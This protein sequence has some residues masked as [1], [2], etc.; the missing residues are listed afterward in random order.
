VSEYQYYEFR[1]LDRELTDGEIDALEAIS[2]RAQVTPTS[3]TNHYDWGDLKADPFKLLEKYFNAFVYVS[4]WGSRRFC[5]RVPKDSIDQEQVERLLK[6]DHAWTS[7]SRQYLILGLEISE[8]DPDFADDGTRWMQALL[9]LRSD[10]LRGD[11]RSLYLGWLLCLQHEEFDAEEPEPAVPAGLGDLAKPLRSLI[12]FL[13]IDPDLIE[14]GAEVSEPLN[15][16][17]NREQ[18]DAWVRALSEQEKNRLLITA[19][20]ESGENWKNEILRRFHS[21]YQPGDSSPKKPPFRTIGDLRAA[22]QLC[23]QR[24]ADKI[25]AI[26]AAEEAQRKALEAENRARYLDLLAGHQETTWTTIHSLIEKRHASPYDQAVRLLIDLRDLAVRQ[27]QEPEFQNKLENL[28][29][30]HSANKKFLERL[31][32]AFCG[33]SDLTP[34][35]P[36]PSA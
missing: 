25:K 34:P 33:Y 18:L 15:A 8:L 22:A 21:G 5:L 31:T 24:R 30:T 28:R 10:I 12:D 14:A 35:S 1:S 7:Q 32:G 16:C 27:R 3:F 29:Q 4:D 6:G 2:T 13:H 17:P 11:F 19:L 23:A 20:L 26:R 9:P 36:P